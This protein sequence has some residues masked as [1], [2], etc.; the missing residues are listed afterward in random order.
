MRGKNRFGKACVSIADCEYE[1]GPC[2]KCAV[3]AA[4]AD[5][6]Q[7]ISRWLRVHPGRSQCAACGEPVATRE[8]I[9]CHEHHA[10]GAVW[11]VLGVATEPAIFFHPFRGP[12]VAIHQACAEKILP[13][14]IWERGQSDIA[15]L[16]TVRR[17]LTGEH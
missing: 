6:L 17:M 16:T 12:Y 8:V 15:D 3:E 7:A 1:L 10:N 9:L 14:G 5:A 4:E 13:F 2:P 11:E